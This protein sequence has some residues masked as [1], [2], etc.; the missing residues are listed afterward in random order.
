MEKNLNNIRKNELIEIKSWN[1]LGIPSTKIIIIS[2]NKEVYHY[3]KYKRKTKFLTD[4]NI[5]M[6]SL[7]LSKTLSDDQFRMLLDFIENK[8]I[9][10]SFESEKIRDYG[11]S[12]FGNY[13]N[14]NI[15]INNNL[16]IVNEL[17]KIIEEV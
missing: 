11:V 8:L 10:K 15:N 4:N 9:G 3:C 12:I 2:K 5:P 13:L 17:K 14:S 1:G 7:Y 16:E 6:E